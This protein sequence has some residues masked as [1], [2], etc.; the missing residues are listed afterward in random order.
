MLRLAVLSHKRRLNL[1]AR[2]RKEVLKSSNSST[3]QIR[4]DK[5]KANPYITLEASRLDIIWTTPVL[6]LEVPS[7][8]FSFL[9][10]VLPLSFEGVEAACKDKHQNR[11]PAQVMEAGVWMII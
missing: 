7:T 2:R 10:W 6:L 5:Q 11:I 8:S 1:T 3:H 9:L 4:Y